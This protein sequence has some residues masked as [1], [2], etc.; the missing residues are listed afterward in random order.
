MEALDRALL[1]KAAPHCDFR[2]ESSSLARELE[3]IDSLRRKYIA[4]LQL[5]QIILG[6]KLEEMIF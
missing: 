4:L 1:K 6:G 3:E 2:G 5:V